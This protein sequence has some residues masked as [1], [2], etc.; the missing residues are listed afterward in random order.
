M[1][2]QVTASAPKVAEIGSNDPTEDC[3]SQ[4]SKYDWPQN[5]AQKI[6][7]KESSNNPTQINNNPD[8]GDY[9]VG[10][11]QINLIGNMRNTRPAE[12]WLL[13]AKNNVK[14]AYS[15][16]VSQGRTFCKTSGWYNSCVAVGIN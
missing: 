12:S 2:E 8:T 13:D 10:C 1:D 6:M 9:S 7:M 14:Y 3:M 16:Y 15:M 4:L 5:D 11:F